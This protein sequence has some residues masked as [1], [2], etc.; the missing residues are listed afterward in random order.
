MIEDDIHQHL[1]ATLVALFDHG[2]KLF[3][4]ILAVFALSSSLTISGHWS[5]EA[6]G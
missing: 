1:D 2:L 4:H 3:D 5:K 6:N